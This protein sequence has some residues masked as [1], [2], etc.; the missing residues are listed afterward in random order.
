MAKRRDAASS[1]SVVAARNFQVDEEG[2]L[3]LL[4]EHPPEAL[5]EAVAEAERYCP[6]R[7]ITIEA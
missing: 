7:A 4:L 2:N 5:R 1:L 3:T 6:Q